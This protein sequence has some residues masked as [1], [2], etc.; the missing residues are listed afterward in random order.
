MDSVVHLADLLLYFHWICCCTFEDS[1]AVHLVDSIVH[2]ADLLLYV[3]WIC[4]CTFGG[5][6]FYTFGG[7]HS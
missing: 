6:C 2:L 7:L 5:L 4:C 3:Q 1:A